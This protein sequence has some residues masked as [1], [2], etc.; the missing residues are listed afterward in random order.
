M[1]MCIIKHRDTFNFTFTFTFM[2]TA[3]K[4]SMLW[5]TVLNKLHLLSVIQEV[6]FNC[7]RYP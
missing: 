6:Y 7:T 3:V 2:F 5:F 1:A 4:T